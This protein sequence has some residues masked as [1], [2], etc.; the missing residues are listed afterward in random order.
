M[1]AAISSRSGARYPSRRSRR[2][3]SSTLSAQNA[4][5]STVQC[6]SSASACDDARPADS[7]CCWAVP[8]AV[9]QCA[10][11]LRWSLASR[12]PTVGCGCGITTRGQCVACAWNQVGGPWCMALLGLVAKSAA[13]EQATGILVL[14]GG[15]AQACIVRASR[16]RQPLHRRARWLRRETAGGPRRSSPIVARARPWP[17]SPRKRCLP[18]LEWQDR[19]G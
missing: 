14:V 2:S 19:V 5:S 4:S 17:A 9:E 16:S 13:A 7:A 6:G 10:S 3:G 12:P 18:R 11:A 1:T 15:A 8:P